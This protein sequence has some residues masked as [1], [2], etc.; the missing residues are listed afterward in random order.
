MAGPLPSDRREFDLT[1]DAAGESRAQRSSIG[2][3]VWTYIIGAVAIVALGA[4]TLSGSIVGTVLEGWGAIIVGV[5]I[6]VV[7]TVYVKFYLGKNEVIRL[8]V[9][10]DGLRF[11]WT[12]GTTTTF[13]WSDPRLK[14]D[15]CH[16]EGNPNDVLPA[17]D[18]RS[19]RPWWIDAWKPAG[20]TIAVETTLPED[21]YRALLA[22]VSLRVPGVQS[23][24]AAYFCWEPSPRVPGELHH[25]S[26]SKLKPGESTNGTLTRVRGTAVI[27]S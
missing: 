27:E 21:A 1:S 5:G 13:A 9:D 11:T 18:P 20:S 4:F 26:G 19:R 25:R 16:L 3:I 15:L 23:V 14:V 6:I 7:G 12:K 8:G 17:D 10:S 24:P 22:E 2:S